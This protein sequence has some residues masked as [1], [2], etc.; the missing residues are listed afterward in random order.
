MP[1]NALFFALAA[2]RLILLHVVYLY[3]PLFLDDQQVGGFLAGVLLSMFAI[4]GFLSAFWSGL[5][6]DRHPVGRLTAVGFACFALF[7][8]GL[9]MSTSPAV[10]LICFLLGGLGN[11]LLEMSLTAYVLKIPQPGAPRRL[12][13][14]Y[15]LVLSLASAT[16]II[17]GGFL[18]SGVGYRATFLATIVG[19][20]VLAGIALLLPTT[21]VAHS[22][23]TEY[24]RDFQ[25]RAMVLAVVGYLLVALHRGA[26]ITSLTPFVHDSLGLEPR[27]IGLFL[28]TALPFLGLGGWLGARLVDRGV[29]YRRVAV[30]G[31]LLS[32]CGHIAFAL[33]NLPVAWP[34]R[35]VHELG[36]GLIWVTQLIAMHRVFPRDRAGGLASVMATA[37]ILGRFAGTLLFAPLG[38]AFG[39]AWPLALS[40]GLVIVGAAFLLPF[41]AEVQQ[42]LRTPSAL[43]LPTVSD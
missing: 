7:A 34:V 36:D 25:G 29:S 42:R 24:A 43:A 39:Y 38:A 40:G 19:Y 16:G 37:M 14:N 21:R 12:F 15:S 32:G 31:L 22:P 20:S 18:L 5:L 4:T 33:S 26:E 10:L 41:F 23:L 35:A 11:T 28:G 27:H 9:C 6:T 3:L 8:V 30:V 17:A 13:G 1:A 2:A